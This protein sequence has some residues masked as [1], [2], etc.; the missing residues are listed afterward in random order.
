MFL[1]FL[2]FD[3]LQQLSDAGLFKRRTAR[4]LLQPI[5]L[6]TELQRIL[7][8]GYASDEMEYHDDVRCLAV[9]VRNAQGSVVA[10]VGITGPLQLF[11]KKVQTDL[12]ASVKQTAID[13]ALS[14]YRPQLVAN[15]ARGQ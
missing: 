15:S 7:A 9:P 10:A 2:H 12:I 8:R 11:A 5:E 14:T 3:Q 13:I 4:S 6:T 1:A